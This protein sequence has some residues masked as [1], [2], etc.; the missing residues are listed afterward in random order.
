MRSVTPGFLIY[1]DKGLMIGDMTVIRGTSL[2]GYLELVREL[3]ADPVPVLAQAGIAPE[4]VGDHDQFL[5]YRRVI[6]ALEAAAAVTGAPDFGRRLALGQGVEILG[7]V[8]VAART[9]PTVGAALEAIQQYLAVYSPAISVDVHPAT[10]PD[11]PSAWLVWAV[12]ASRP[13]AHPQSTE[14]AIGVCFKVFKLLAGDG[15][16]PTAVHLRHEP[17]GDP[18]DYLRYFGTTVRFSREENGFSFPVELIGR[19]LSSDAAMHRVAQEYLG[20]LTPGAADEIV[21]PVRVLVRRML[22]TG[23]LSLDL[24]AEQLALHPR[25]LQ[26]RLAQEGRTY[27]EVLDEVRRGEAER[28][29]GNPRL[30]LTQVAGLLGFSEQSVLTHACRRWFGSTPTAYRRGS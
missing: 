14:L 6:H 2:L 23:G 3:G 22:P 25:T 16:R 7:P 8:G 4:A 11:D 24:V 17:L 18:A 5:D 26:R 28:H 21:E 20:A 13:P 9:A 10:D 30:T 29:L 27:A 1:D 12:R 15:F 19:R